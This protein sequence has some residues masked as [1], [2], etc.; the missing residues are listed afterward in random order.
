MKKEMTKN[1][2][3][4]YLLKEINQYWDS[5]KRYRSMIESIESQ[6]EKS[7]NDKMLIDIMKKDKFENIEKADLV[8][9]ILIDCFGV[10][11]YGEKVG[12]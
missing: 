10:N 5:V 3:K 6:E 12:E 1:Q 4:E 8:E 2:M 7:E 9:N 11:M